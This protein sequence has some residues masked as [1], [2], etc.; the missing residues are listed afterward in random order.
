MDSLKF[1]VNAVLPI[2]IMVAIGY[3]LRRIGFISAD[4]AKAAN[5]LVFR[6]FLPTML[7]LNVYNISASMNIGMGYIGFAIGATFVIFAV[8][9]LLVNV[10]TK[11][12]KRRAPVIQ[13][14]FRSNYALIGI[15]LAEAFFG[16]EGAAVASLLSAFS[17]PLFNV[18]AV[19]AFAVFGGSENRP[20]IKKIVLDIVKN[21]LI[22]GS[23]CG[24]LGLFF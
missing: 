24:F 10:A 7:F 1:A 14:V 23:V 9:I 6:V 21:P 15:P 12:K 13:A 3:F 2:I 8:S 16:A 18:L 4:F 19:I 17:I 22:I 20:S 5:K 11:N